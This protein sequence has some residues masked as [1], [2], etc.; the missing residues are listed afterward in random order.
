MVWRARPQPIAIRTTRI[1]LYTVHLEAHGGIDIPNIIDALL[2][3]LVASA[4]VK[5]PADL[6]PLAVR[7]L[8]EPGHVRKIGTNGGRSI[9]VVHNTVV[10]AGTAAV[11]GSLHCHVAFPTLVDP[12]S[13]CGRTKDLEPFRML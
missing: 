6:Y 11:G 8:Y 12:H 4:A 3:L 5:I 1:H 13:A 2:D 9:R 7:V 10:D